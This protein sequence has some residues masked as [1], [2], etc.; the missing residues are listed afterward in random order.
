[1]STSDPTATLPLQIA[2]IPPEGADPQDIRLVVYNGWDEP[3]FEG[4]AGADL[5]LAAGLYTVRWSYAG[6]MEEQVVRL[7]HVRSLVLQVKRSTPAPVPGA[8]DTHEYYSGYNGDVNK[9]LDTG[10]AIGAEG[11]LD[12]RLFLMLRMRSA[13]QY[14]GEDL[15]A[16][17]RLLD[18]GLNPLFELGERAL[19]QNSGLLLCSLRAQPGCYYLEYRPPEPGRAARLF[20]LHLFGGWQTRLYLFYEH[21]QLNFSSASISLRNAEYQDSYSYQRQRIDA[22]ADMALNSLQANRAELPREIENGLLYAKFENPLLGILGAHFLLQRP[23]QPTPEAEA[24]LA[25]KTQM[26]FYN[27]DDLLPYS[28][29][30]AALRYKAALRFPTLARFRS[31]GP[32]LKDPPMLRASL[33]A[34]SLAEGSGIEAIVEGSPLESLAPN[35]F[36]DSPW[37]TF[38]SPMVQDP[39]WGDGTLENLGMVKGPEAMPAAEPW[40]VSTIR[41]A[42][43]LTRGSGREPNWGGLA[44]SLGIS[45]RKMMRMVREM[46]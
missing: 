4:A 20:P 32:L 46:M 12:S 11:A 41:Q 38:R 2:L 31:P 27:L 9:D 1:M 6:V 35:L 7:P 25:E 45:M 14:R 15:A 37:A 34:L 28:P 17:L 26:V 10:A 42:V 29:D 13:E 22:A 43:E 18:G 21:G 40:M 30:V 19:A 44:S 24:K 5:R 16:G 39:D 3:V 23:A 33:E 8:I 36:F